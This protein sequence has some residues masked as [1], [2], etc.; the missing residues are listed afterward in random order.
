MI[1]SQYS[2]GPAVTPSYSPA[3]NTPA[4]PVDSRLAPAF[5]PIKSTHSSDKAANRSD[6]EADSGEQDSSRVSAD[7]SQETKKQRGE[8]APA[9]Q[10][11]EQELATLEKLKQRH[12]EV[13][14][15]EQAHQAVGGR[16]AGSASYQYETGPDGG[17]Y[18]VSGEVPIRL[19]SSDAEPNEKLQQA[20]QVIRAALAP[21][22]PSAQDRSVA[23]RATEIK[24]DAQQELRELNDARS[25]EIRASDAYQSEQSRP[26]Q[27][28]AVG[29]TVAVS[30]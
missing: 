23:A 5:T 6:R 9:G 10:L 7:E 3:A 4:A 11:S 22:E 1:S 17:R 27:K 29:S 30:A 24:I 28:S 19:P 14:A 15:H 25:N 26:D 16:F 18:A 13:V 20:D 21:A 8:Q 2:S 12:R